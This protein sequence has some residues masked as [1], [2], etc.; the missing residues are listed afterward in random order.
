MKTYVIPTLSVLDFR[1][2]HTICGGSGASPAAIRITG[3]LH[4]NGAAEDQGNAL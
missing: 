1:G 2:H 3:T 4:S